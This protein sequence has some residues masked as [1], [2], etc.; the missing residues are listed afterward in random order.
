MKP[1]RNQDPPAY[2]PIITHEET[3]A[4]TS[5]LNYEMTSEIQGIRTPIF[6]QD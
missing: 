5:L 4:D 6:E 2:I 1:A 3:D